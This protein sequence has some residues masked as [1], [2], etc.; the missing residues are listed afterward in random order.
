MTID[1]MRIRESIFK[2]NNAALAH[3]LCQTCYLLISLHGSIVIDG[4]EFLTATSLFNKFRDFNFDLIKNHKGM[5]ML[6]PTSA[7]QEFVDSILKGMK[8]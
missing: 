7:D 8:K 5:T 4:E 2:R 3:A 1:E 6:W